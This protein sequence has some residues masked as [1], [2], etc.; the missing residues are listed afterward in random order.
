MSDN[1]DFYSALNNFAKE[2]KKGLKEF[3]KSFAEEAE[4]KPYGERFRNFSDGFGSFDFNLDINDFS[5]PKHQSYKLDDGSLV[6]R[7]M[8]PGFDEKGIDLSFKGDMMILKA[9]LA[10]ELKEDLSHSTQRFFA[11]DIDRKEYKVPADQYEQGSSKAVYKNG[12]LTVTIPP[13]EEDDSYSIKVDIHK[14]SE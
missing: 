12:V 1:F 8:L 2:I 3:S 6:Y 10:P 4:A 13:K 11:R 9:K 5:Y 7:F 14:D